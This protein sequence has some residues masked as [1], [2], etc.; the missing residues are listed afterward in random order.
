MDFSKM[1]ENSS[2]GSTGNV[3]SANTIKYISRYRD[4]VLPVSSVVKPRDRFS[5]EAPT[6]YN[7]VYRFLNF[8]TQMI[9]NYFL[10]K[11][12]KLTLLIKI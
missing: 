7:D 2:D 3:L 10:I 8:S 6:C 12:L 5:S 1:T 9:M 11:K 4:P